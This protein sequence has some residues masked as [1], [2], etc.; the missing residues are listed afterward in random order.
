MAALGALLAFPGSAWAEDAPKPKVHSA[1]VRDA[2]TAFGRAYRSKEPAERVRAVQALAKLQDKKIAKRLLKCLRPE[3]D[4]GV[5]GTVFTALGAQKASSASTLPKLVKRLTDE[6]AVER[7]RIANRDC[8][9]LMHPK[10]GEVDEH[11]AAGKARLAAV[12]RRG[13]MLATLMETLATLAWPVAKETLELTPLLLDPVD[14]LVVAVLARMGK[15]KSWTALP[16]VLALY[17]MYPVKALWQTGAVNNALGTPAQAKADWMVRFGHPD[18]QR[19]RPKVVVA[20]RTMLKAVTGKDF[21][22]PEALAA[23]LQTSDV[24]KRVRGR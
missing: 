10:T 3:K 9:L 7:K 21:D 4:A 17:Q 5:L 12:S 20:I 18:K 1:Q 19:A 16:E 15:T 22:T 11:T 14:D 23:Y 6:V 2:L 13:E 24:K 8:G